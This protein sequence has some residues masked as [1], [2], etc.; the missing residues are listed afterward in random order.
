MVPFD[1]RGLVTAMGGD[2]AA[3]NARLDGFFHQ[4]DGS[5]ALTVSGGMHAE[6]DN[7]PSLGT[8]WIY[9]FTGQPQRAQETVRRALV[10]LWS[11]TPGGIPGNDDLG[12]MSSWYV[13]AALGIYPYYPGRA[14]LVFGSPLFPAAIVERAQGRTLAIRA[15]Q[16]RA[17]MPYVTDLRVNGKATTKLWLPESFLDAAGQLD[18]TLAGKPDP[19]WGSAPTDAPPSFPPAP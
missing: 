12:E 17:E 6:L 5:W 9:L 4:A 19:S 14:E 2:A 3:I 8:P 7:E 10:S 18:F 11:N 1:V 15:P 13:F 16:A